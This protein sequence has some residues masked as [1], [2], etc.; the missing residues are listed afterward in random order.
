MSNDDFEKNSLRSLLFSLQDI[1]ADWHF[2]IKDKLIKEGLEVKGTD[3]ELSDASFLISINHSETQVPTH[4]E[5]VKLSVADFVTNEYLFF[6][7]YFPAILIFP[8]DQLTISKTVNN[9]LIIKLNKEDKIYRPIVEDTFFQTQECKNE[10]IK[11]LSLN[12][13]QQ[14]KYDLKKVL[15]NFFEI[16]KTLKTPE[17]VWEWFNI[18]DSYSFWS[19]LNDVQALYEANAL[20]QGPKNTYYFISLFQLMQKD[21]INYMENRPN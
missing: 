19:G 10:L 12:I 8:E 5:I 4:V 21:L 7:K 11:R 20:L 6:R 18:Q 15:E 1:Y 16:P 3:I 2:F 9:T 13:R 14:G 17:E